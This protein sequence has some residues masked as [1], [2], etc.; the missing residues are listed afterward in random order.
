[1]KIKLITEDFKGSDYI[2]STDCPLF[3]AMKRLSYPVHNVG[4]ALDP[5]AIDENNKIIATFDNKLWNGS[6]AYPLIDK[7]DQGEEVEYELEINLV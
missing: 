7:A 5:E 3:R 6:I 4:G 1:M 2:D